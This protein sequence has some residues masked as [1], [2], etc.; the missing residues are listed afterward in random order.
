[1][2]IIMTPKEPLTSALA[3]IVKK[4]M[5]PH[6]ERED[7]LQHRQRLRLRPGVGAV[8]RPRFRISPRCSCASVLFYLLLLPVVLLPWGLSPVYGPHD[9]GHVFATGTM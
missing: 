1:M 7:A 5:R 8:R 3:A 6:E 4:L 9:L 2:I